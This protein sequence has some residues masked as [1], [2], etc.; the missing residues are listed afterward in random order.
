MLPICEK[1]DKVIVALELLCGRSENMY[2]RG[3]AQINWKSICA[4]S[5]VGFLFLWSSV[6]V[7]VDNTQR[8]L[9][10]KAISLERA[11]VQLQALKTYLPQQRKSVVKNALQNAIAKCDDYGI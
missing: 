8:Y 10:E 5:Y 3:A 7:E 1:Y 6:L 9:Q 2:T 4:F 11:V